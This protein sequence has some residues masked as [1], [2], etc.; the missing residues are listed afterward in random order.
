MNFL[1]IQNDKVPDTIEPPFKII[2]MLS[3]EDL[4]LLA[5]E[6]QDNIVDNESISSDVRR[7]MGTLLHLLGQWENETQ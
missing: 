5:A 2:Q 4:Q 6:I 1:I 7:V 3:D